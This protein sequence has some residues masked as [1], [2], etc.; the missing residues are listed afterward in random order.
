LEVAAKGHCP[1][2]KRLKN[3]LKNKEVTEAI[4]LGGDQNQLKILLR[5][6]PINWG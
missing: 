5:L 2:L 6:A 3:Y 4:F 1:L